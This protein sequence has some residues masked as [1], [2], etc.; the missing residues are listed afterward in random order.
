MTKPVNRTH[1]YNSAHRRE[2]ANTTRRDIIEAARRLLEK[3]GYTAD[4]H[5][6]RRP[7]GGCSAQNGL[8]V[9]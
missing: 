9:L 2:Q 1:K 6:R 4:D 7:G 8:P 5:G 3:D